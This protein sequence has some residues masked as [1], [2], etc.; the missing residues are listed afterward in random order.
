MLALTSKKIIQR[1]KA[2]IRV[3]QIH[4]LL[5]QPHRFVIRYVK[6]KKDNDSFYQVDENLIGKIH[7]YRG[8]IYNVQVHILLANQELPDGF[9]EVKSRQLAKRVYSLRSM[10]EKTILAKFLYYFNQMKSRPET[11][12][13]LNSVIESYSDEVSEILEKVE[14]KGIHDYVEGVQ[15][16]KISRMRLSSEV[17]SSKTSVQKKTK[18]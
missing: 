7:D 13:D 15:K 10:W 18:N 4:K 1:L 16:S 12:D 5:H 6:S 17:K 14:E 3:I 9:E 11:C 8:K 2:L